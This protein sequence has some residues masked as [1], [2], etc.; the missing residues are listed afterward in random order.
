[1]KFKLFV[2][3][4]C[5]HALIRAQTNPSQVIIGKIDTIHSNIL[6]EYRKI[7]IY[8]PKVD[9]DA[10]YGR[11][12]YPVVYLLD[13]DAHFSTVTSMIRQLSE[14]FTSFFP[15]MIVVGILN[16]DRMRDLTQRTLKVLLILRTAPFLNR[17]GE[18]KN[19]WLSWKKN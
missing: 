10:G 3:F 1:V 13:G 9:P 7:W 2:L 11:V 19:S 18:V 15:Q 8:A 6:N 14:G 5:L 12:K 4:I 17:P 16:T